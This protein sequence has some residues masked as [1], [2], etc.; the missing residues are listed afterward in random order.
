LEE[1]VVSITK[2]KPSLNSCPV[3]RT[4]F[5]ICPLQEFILQ[6][7]DISLLH[8][9]FLILHKQPFILTT[10]AEPNM[11]PTSQGLKLLL[12]FAV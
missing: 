10:N 5:H 9:D 6:G 3:N 2:K 8:I 11:N 1:K 4:P 12:R 7:I